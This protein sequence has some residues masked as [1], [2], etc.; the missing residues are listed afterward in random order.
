MR[1]PKI[2]SFSVQAY[3]WF[4]LTPSFVIIYDQIDKKAVFI[5]QTFLLI[6]RIRFHDVKLTVI[7]SIVM[8]L[9]VD[10]YVVFCRLN[11]V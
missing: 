7:K 1:S 11:Q 2:G 10:S 8:I 4:N 9:N 5:S 3:I 6:T